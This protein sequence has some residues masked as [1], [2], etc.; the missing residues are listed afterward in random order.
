MEERS[1][2]GMEESKIG[3]QTRMELSKEQSAGETY[4]TKSLRAE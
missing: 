4:E 2:T 3:S 1:A